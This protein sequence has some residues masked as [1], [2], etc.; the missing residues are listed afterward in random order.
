MIEKPGLILVEG[1]DCLHLLRNQIKEQPDFQHI[2][3]YDYMDGGLTL[4]AFLNALQ[5]QIEW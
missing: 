5:C 3:L 1:V 4:N 2:W